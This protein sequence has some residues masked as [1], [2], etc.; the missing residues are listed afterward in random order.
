MIHARLLPGLALLIVAACGHDKQEVQVSAASK[1]AAVD[2]AKALTVMPSGDSLSPEDALLPIGNAFAGAGALTAVGSAS[3]TVTGSPGV[4]G[5][6]EGCLQIVPGKVTFNRCTNDEGLTLNGQVTYG[7]GN[8][9]A[10]LSGSADSNG[11][12]VTFN[13]NADLHVS[14]THVSGSLHVA[15]TIMSSGVSAT[16]TV[17]SS[18]DIGYTSGCPTSGTMSVDA[19]AQ[20]NGQSAAVSLE[21]QFGPNCGD[22][23][24][25][26]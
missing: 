12:K 8:F 1:A 24:F 19:I 5:L 21:A 23:K 7:S 4:S 26:K 9:A 25:F 6:P 10:T 11:T 16:A 13:E 3:I 14:A 15:V 18:Y 2:S 20:G 17:D 22:V